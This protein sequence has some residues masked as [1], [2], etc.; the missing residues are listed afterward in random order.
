MTVGILF[1]EILPKN[2]TVSYRA[3]MLGKLVIPLSFIRILMSPFRRSAK[4]Q[5]KR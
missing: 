2:L 5:S 1:A 3:E 4:S